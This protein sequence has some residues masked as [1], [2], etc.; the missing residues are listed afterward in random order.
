MQT[1]AEHLSETKK[2]NRDC[3]LLEAQTAHTDLVNLSKRAERGERVSGKITAAFKR[4]KAAT[5]LAEALS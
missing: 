5:K 1:F 3:A 2:I 4:H